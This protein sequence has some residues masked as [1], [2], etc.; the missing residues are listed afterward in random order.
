MAWNWWTRLR[1][2]RGHIDLIDA[3]QVTGWAADRWG[4][5]Q[6]LTIQVDGRAIDRI[7]PG[8]IRGDLPKRFGKP[9]NVGFDYVFEDPLPGGAILSITDAVGRQLSN[10]PQ[11]IPPAP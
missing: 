5:A 3:Y 8:Y 4:L 2:F 6:E 9:S 7:V 10:S 11:I 1:G